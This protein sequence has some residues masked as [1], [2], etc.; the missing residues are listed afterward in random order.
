[1]AES[2]LRYARFG[3]TVLLGVRVLDFVS[4]V[5]QPL[6]QLHN[7]VRTHNY[8]VV[9]ILHRV[10]LDD[11]NL[12]PDNLNYQ[13][14]CGLSHKNKM[15]IEIQ[16]TELGIEYRCNE[17]FLRGLAHTLGEALDALKRIKEPTSSATT[18]N[19]KGE[20]PSPDHDVQ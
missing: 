19:A 9:V 10:G 18:P 7:L 13:L 6:N 1:M 5:A 4:R 2:G 14:L 12:A 17:P 20:L 15:K 16:T 8:G 3:P 11:V